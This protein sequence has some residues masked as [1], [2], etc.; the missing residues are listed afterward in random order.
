VEAYVTGTLIVYIF[1]NL[2]YRDSI[3]GMKQEYLSIVYI[4]HC[5][6]G[7]R[8]LLRRSEAAPSLPSTPFLNQVYK[9]TTM[10]LYRDRIAVA[11]HQTF[12]SGESG[13]CGT[14]T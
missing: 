10:S 6:P 5:R 3:P 4:G 2:E 11:H 13:L 8:R 1:R 14:Y 7:V 12:E 9:H